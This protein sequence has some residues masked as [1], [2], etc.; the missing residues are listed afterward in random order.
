[1]FDDRHATIPATPALRRRRSRVVGALAGAAVLLLVLV[2]SFANGMFG[3]TKSTLPSTL[4]AASQFA[5]RNTTAPAISGTTQVGRQLTADKGSWMGSGNSYAYQWQRCYNADTCYDEA[6]QTGT[7]YTIPAWVLDHRVRVVVTAT[8]AAGS[9]TAT[10]A[11]TAAAFPAPPA[12]TSLPTVVGNAQWRYTLSSTHGAWSSDA[13]AP[14]TYSYQWQSCAEKAGQNCTDVSGATNATYSLQDVA[15][16]DTY[17]RVKVTADNGFGSATAVS[18]TAER[19]RY[20]DAG[21]LT[22][23]KDPDGIVYLRGQVGPPVDV[24]FPWVIGT[25]PAGYRPSTRVILAPAS[26]PWWVSEVDV[27]PNGDVVLQKAATSTATQSRGQVYFGTNTFAAAAST[28]MTDTT[29]GAGNAG[30]TNRG[31]AYAPFSGGVDRSGL[32][33][34]SGVLKTSQAWNAGDVIGNL[35]VELRPA[36]PVMAKATAGTLG[37]ARLDIMPSGDIVLQGWSLGATDY[38][39][40]GE[41]L[42]GTTDWI[43][44]ESITYATAGSPL[45]WTSPAYGDGWASYGNGFPGA[46]LTVDANRSAHLRGVVTNPGFYPRFSDILAMPAATREL[47][48]VYSSALAW[49]ADTG[50]SVGM[51][52]MKDPSGNPAVAWLS[53]GVQGSSWGGAGSFET[54]EGTLWP[55][56]DTAIDFRDLP[57]APPQAPAATT[58]P[59][60]SGSPNSGKTITVSNG[61]WTGTPASYAYQWKRCDAGGSSCTAIQGETA[62]SYVVQDSDVG[63]T[64]RATVT[65]T[66]PGG[67][68]S[69]TSAAGTALPARPVNLTAPVISGTPRSGWYLSTTNG[70]W[71]APAS[72]P[73]TGY[74]YLWQTCADQAETDC[75]DY[76]S[77]AKPY[78]WNFAGRHMRVR[79]TAT[80]AGGSTSVTVTGPEANSETG[81]GYGYAKDPDGIVHF[82][83]GGTTATVSSPFPHV[84]TTLP[85]GYRPAQ[86]IVESVQGWPYVAYEIDIMPNGDVVMQSGIPLDVT[87]W[88]NVNNLSWPAA[89]S[90]VI[91]DTTLGAGTAGWTDYGSGYAGY[92]A[93]VDSQGFAHLYGLLKTTQTW[94]ADDVIGHLNPTALHPTVPVMARATIGTTGLARVDIVPDGDIILRGW[95]FDSGTTQFEWLSLS[96]IS[97]ETAAAHVTWNDATYINGFTDYGH[98]FKGAQYAIDGNGMVHVRGVITNPTPFPRGTG[99]MSGGFPGFATV[100]VTLAWNP[101]VGYQVAGNFWF[102]PNAAISYLWPGTPSVEYGGPE[103][104]ITFDGGFEWPMEDT[105]LNFHLITVAPM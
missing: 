33:H 93:G 73:V 6:G 46:E 40:D 8:N 27:D 26:F 67:T 49:N 55:T 23:G 13:V 91:S 89:D 3:S 29:L 54:L 5:P 57:L 2:V 37:L 70:T 9:E 79:V 82:D 35:P 96:G 31:S 44:L 34:L 47:D 11:Q 18:D 90:T 12:N 39:L 59:S 24:Q 28:I 81:G 80:N 1:M 52:Q 102:Y 63:S 64:L 30:W 83:L 88:N 103:S 17:L 66:G 101:T 65:A 78:I 36:S 97:Y 86:R 58:A 53:P 15:Y 71:S 25:L 74:S 94:N 19:V 100:G 50:Y 61:T 69:A 38:Y 43:S 87:H 72:A 56:A 85:P 20:G 104:W 95:R 84:I 62:S 92:S 99:Y 98:G 32:A 105:K 60:I 10:S 21:D 16:N 41:Q 48:S 22:Y 75:S 68:T 42:P 51:M 14:T 7:T 45:V 4:Q 76:S 77:L